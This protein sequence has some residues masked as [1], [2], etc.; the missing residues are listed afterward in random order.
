[1]NMPSWN[2]GQYLKFA[3][4]RSRP[5]CD[6][7]AQVY[8][9]DA[10]RIIDLGCGPGNSTEVVARRW[11]NAEIIG[12]D[13]SAQMIESARNSQPGKRWVVGDISQWAA[14]ASSEP[15]LEDPF[16]L[17]FSNAALQ[18]VPDHA[19]LLPRLLARLNPGGALAIQVP[20]NFDSP[21][22]ELM[23]EIAISPTWYRSFPPG[24]V[25]EWHVHDL[26]FYYDVLAPTAERVDFWETEYLHVM[27]NAEAIVEWYKG[28]GLR[29]FLDALATDEDR[30]RFTAEYLDGITGMYAARDNGKVLFP[31]RRLFLIAYAP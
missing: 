19:E 11:P 26:P 15:A 13:S 22:H 21:A 6:L 23:R 14:G 8:V 16:D 31:F 30:A 24:K 18:W 2:P 1:M 10:K 9:P 20:G 3:G 28:S 29:P 17:V 25:R 12:F 4:E 7:A 5:C 27:D